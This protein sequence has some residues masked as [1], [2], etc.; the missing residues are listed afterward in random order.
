MAL[1]KG[2]IPNEVKDPA[3]FQISRAVPIFFVTLLTA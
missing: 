3:L 1:F 2:V